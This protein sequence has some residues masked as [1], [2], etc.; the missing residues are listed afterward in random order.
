MT[1]TQNTT[2]TMESAQD[3]AILATGGAGLLLLGDVGDERLRRQHHGCD[4]GRVLEGGAGDLAG[5]HDALISTC[6]EVSSSA[7]DP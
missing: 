1:T 5:V 6:A 3:L 2:E 4:R 7:I